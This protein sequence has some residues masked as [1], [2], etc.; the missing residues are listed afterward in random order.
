[1]GILDDLQK[2]ESITPGCPLARAILSM[3]EEEA[4][5]V[6]SALEDAGIKGSVLTDILIKNGYNISH[7]NVSRHR[8][9]LTGEG[10]T[11]CS[12]PAKK[13]N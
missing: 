3:N 13:G 8:K 4:S 2:V 7:T 5:A 1:M 10:G 9:M 11:K 12:C 6:Q